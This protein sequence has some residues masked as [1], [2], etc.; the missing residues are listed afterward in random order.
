MMKKNSFKIR[1][2]KALTLIAFAFCAGLFGYMEFTQLTCVGSVEQVALSGV[3][4][5]E[6]RLSWSTVGGADGYYIYRGFK[7]EFHLAAIISGGKADSFTLG[8]LSPGCEYYFYVN[9]VKWHGSVYESKTHK[10]VFVTTESDSKTPSSK[11]IEIKKKYSEESSIVSRVNPNKPMVALTFDDG[12][13]YNASSDKIL[14]VL[15]KYGARATFFMVGKNARD[16]PENLSRKIELGCEL[17][18]HTSDHQHY[19]SNITVEDISNASEDIYAACGRYPTA[20]RSPGGNTT[21]LILNECKNE[22]MA[23]YYWSLD[24]KDWKLRNS[25][26]IYD[27]VMNNV[28][29]G[30]IILMHEIYDST[31][32]AIARIVPELINRGY[33]LVTCE[34]LVVCKTGSKPEPGQQYLNGET[35]VNSTS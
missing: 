5:T 15:E 30:D 1:I 27:V 10:T 23:A 8:G 17:G 20:F 11:A 7:G 13:G 26:K 16:H 22:N 2:I 31:A 28:S 33:Q 3:G 12:P 25:Q 9:A 4:K 35:I 19:G 34:E 18:N 21:P 24:T 6:A 32:E 29:D 14:D